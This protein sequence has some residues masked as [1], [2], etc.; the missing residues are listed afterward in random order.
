MRFPLGQFGGA[1][2]KTIGND[3]KPAGKISQDKL[4]RVPSKRGSPAPKK[5]V[6]DNLLK[7]AQ[8]VGDLLQLFVGHCPPSNT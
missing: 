8:F 5:E 4:F 3:P 1:L 7:I 6:C 2:F